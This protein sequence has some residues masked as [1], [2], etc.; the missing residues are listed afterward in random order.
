[1]KSILFF[2]AALCAIVV[3][4]T[5]GQATETQHLVV[6]EETQPLACGGCRSGH[7]ACS[8]CKSLFLFATETQQLAGCGCKGRGKDQPT[9]ACK[10]KFPKVIKGVP[11][12][13]TELAC[14][15]EDLLT[16]HKTA[17]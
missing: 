2:I 5:Q 10:H 9:I 6:V 4:P 11:S 3:T 15:C 12:T 7:V 1:M 8:G 13:S 14:E 16:E 17:A